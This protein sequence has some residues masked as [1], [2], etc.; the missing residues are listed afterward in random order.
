MSS[1]AVI[2]LE[3]PTGEVKEI[4]LS[5]KSPVS[6]G[7]H[8]N[9][10]VQLKEP[11][12]GTMHCR[13]SLTDKGIVIAAATS[14]GV[15]INGIKTRKTILTENDKVT[16]GGTKL[17]VSGEA[18]VASSRAASAVDLKPVSQDDIFGDVAPE[19]PDDQAETIKSK[20]PPKKQK[21]PPPEESAISAILDD[22]DF[23]EDDDMFAPADNYASSSDSDKTEDD[24]VEEDAK[25]VSEDE[26]ETTD[27]DKPDEEKISP[28]EKLRS[29]M[30]ARRNRSAVRPGQEEL[31][32]SKLLQFL[33]GGSLLL[34]VLAAI[35]YVLFL[36]NDSQQLYDNALTQFEEKKYS[37]SIS[38]FN[39]FLEKYPNVTELSDA[40][41]IK[42]GQA[43]IEKEIA[44]SGGNWEAGLQQLDNFIIDNRGTKGFVTDQKG[45]LFSYANTIARGAIASAQTQKK[46][47]FLAF[48]KE[49]REKVT[50]YGPESE[51][52]MK[53][54]N[55]ELDGLY[56]A[57]ESAVLKEEVFVEHLQRIETAI[58]SKQPLAALKTRRELLIRYPDLEENKKLKEKMG[59][60][61]ETEQQLVTS[62]ELDQEAIVVEREA[63]YPPPLTIAIHTRSQTPGQSEG[64]VV[65]IQTQNSCYGIDT[66][67]GQPVWQRLTGP[68]K[69]FF[70]IL[71]DTAPEGVIFFDSQHHELVAIELTTG[72]LMW[73]QPL[74][75]ADGNPEQVTGK[76]L[77][78][79]SSIFIATDQNNLYQLDLRSG[80]L[81]VRLHFAQ[82]LFG[83]PALTADERHCLI[84]GEQELFYYF[85]LRPLKCEAVSYFGHL[86]GDI[87]IPIISMGSLALITQN[88]GADECTLKV[89]RTEF[90]DNPAEFPQK[91]VPEAQE[92]IAGRVV[93][94]PFLRG[95]Q[96]VVH[97]TGKRLTSFTVSADPGTQ[98]L[99][100]DGAFQF[101]EM[102][103]EQTGETASVNP[104]NEQSVYLYIGP[105]GQLWMSQDALRKL[106]INSDHFQLNPK[107]TATGAP[108]QP[109]QMQ[110]EKVFVGRSHPFS[111]AVFLSQAN[112]QSLDS[113][114]RTI[115]GAKV[116]GT[117]EANEA[118][119]TCLTDAGS[120]VQVRKSDFQE[121]R[122][123]TESMNRLPLDQE[124][125]MSD[126]P[127]RVV[128]MANGQM[129]VTWGNADPFY[130]TISKTGQVT[131]ARKLSAPVEA[132]P[133]EI[134]AGTVLPVADNLILI[135][136]G[137]N[138]R[139]VINDFKTPD[140]SW[141]T[142]IPLSGN[143]FLGLTDAG[144]LARYEF[145]TDNPSHFREITNYD[146]GVPVDVAPVLSGETLFLA[147]SDSKLQVIDTT[148][149][150]VTNTID[151]PA[152]ASGD[153]WVA[154]ET[155]LV[156]ADNQLWGYP[157][158]GDLKPTWN[159]PLDG[160]SITVEPTVRGTTMFAADLSGRILKV[161]LQSGEMTELGVL[162]V[163][164]VLPLF[165]FGNDV[166]GATVDGSLY[167]L[168]S[169]FSQ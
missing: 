78:H 126:T 135:P 48:A 37:Q 161:D 74:Q 94:P 5:S 141:K 65:L 28:K 30:E 105:N 104:S 77:V 12:V 70:P 101:Q 148:S 131:P 169:L 8:R 119:L 102:Q 25:E 60:I 7:A 16:I 124:K 153:L 121:K 58:Q 72:K 142:L 31:L 89:L 36:S 111:P 115:F 82:P 40:A 125:S 166:I 14:A 83:S 19:E 6:I 73:R 157:V 86:P 113:Y 147:T 21:T 106:Q 42:L 136:S 96:L 150:T 64:E 62:T 167:Q 45:V 165:A 98:M 22:D 66:I 26:E 159:N 49:A 110:H 79:D 139:Q 23:L 51:S 160:G 67:T 88:T 114:W 87:D 127:P 41:R 53:A 168:S 75:T 91:I 137:A 93:N 84:A 99:T 15:N 39:G 123:L 100:E 57:A 92:K 10:D 32:R 69:S 43:K 134:E 163:P 4:E 38:S 29:R 56:R 149:L 133:I 155:L 122:F 46:R 130:S 152:S 50:A 120:V 85:S 2:K 162:D 18:A 52:E 140:S 117:I 54:L 132:N 47:E 128:T 1:D 3:L 76:P 90:P 24:A 164:L 17:T 97:S 109:L 9:N 145:T 80:R 138:S 13:L 144:F 81:M 95:K 63:S 112:R 11:G 44:G 154:G 103:E 108:V 59:Q 55:Q 27:D 107:E 151:L 35:F 33:G 71:V 156:Q 20:K 68:E 116:I 146:F 158:T 34:I 118:T 143:E 129:F 61:L